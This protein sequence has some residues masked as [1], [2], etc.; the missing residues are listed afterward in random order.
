VL[1]S[2]ALALRGREATTG[3]GSVHHEVTFAAKPAEVYEALMDSRRHAAFSGV[4]AKISR[5][6]GGA[7]HCY[8]GSI[9]GRNVELREGSR[10]VQAWRIADWDDGIYSIVRFE[11]SKTKTGTQLV[12]DHTGIP[13]AARDGIEDGWKS[14]YWE[15]IRKYL[16]AKR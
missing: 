16:S 12:F 8:D 4:P 14:H 10:I 15:P 3:W 11:L 2:P 1:R 7:F 13:E 5:V 6:E 9:E